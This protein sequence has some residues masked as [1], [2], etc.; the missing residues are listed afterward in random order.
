MAALL[1]ARPIGSASAGSAGGATVTRA[2]H[3]RPGPGWVG[4]GF[5]V[6]LAAALPAPAA[7]IWLAA[8][9]RRRALAGVG[10]GVLALS[11]LAFLAS[12][13]PAAACWLAAGIWPRPGGRPR[14]WAVA[15][16]VVSVALLAWALAV[17][18]SLI[19]TP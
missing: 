12:P 16:P 3:W 14:A 19:R 9:G 5:F 6:L 15:Q 8:R 2:V 17:A 4:V 7:V 11:I 1:L 18:V 13:L 10:A